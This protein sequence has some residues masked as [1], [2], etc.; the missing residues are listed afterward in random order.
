M[1]II[2]IFL[3]RSWGISIEF[4]VRLRQISQA[5]MLVELSFC[6]SNFAINLGNNIPASD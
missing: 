1:R 2:N 4:V 6:Y 5:V 3:N